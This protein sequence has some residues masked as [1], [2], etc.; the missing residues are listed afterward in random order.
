MPDSPRIRIIPG[1]RPTCPIA[2]GRERTP[3]EMFS[4]LITVEQGYQ[5]KYQGDDGRGT[6]EEILRIPACLM[7]FILR[8]ALV[9]IGIWGK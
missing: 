3:S 4:A 5:R 2:D 7:E 9:D 8:S 1:T 6:D